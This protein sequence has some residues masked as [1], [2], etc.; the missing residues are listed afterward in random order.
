MSLRLIQLVS[1]F[2]LLSLAV[3]AQQPQLVPQLPPDVQQPGQVV[4]K[5][6]PVQGPEPVMPPD[7]QPQTPAQVP[8]AVQPVVTPAVVNTAVPSTPTQ[9]APKSEPA[10]R[11]DADK[12]AAKK[13]VAPVKADAVP[14]AKSVIATKTKLV[15]KG[16]GKK[17]P[18]K[19]PDPAPPPPPPP[20]LTPEQQ[21]P[22]PP[23]VS[24]L[25]GQ[26]TI[27]STNATLSAILTAIRQQ[28]GAQID[29]P[30]GAGSERVATRIGPGS[31]R[32]VLTSLLAGSAFDYV[33]LGNPDSPGS[34]QRV[35]LTQRSGGAGM[36]NMA[37]QQP[38]ASQPAADENSDEDNTEPDTAIEEQPAPVETPQPNPAVAGQPQPGMQQ[39]QQ[40]PTPG[41]ATPPPDQQGQQGNQIKTPEQLYQELQRLQQQQ[42]Q[43]Q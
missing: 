9:T 7:M 26:L 1:I 41:T 10:L 43:K 42:Q 18:E 40:M 35:I 15:A 12:T 31:P 39:P 2:A 23:Q 17:E 3:A 20:P 37:A 38:V 13:P 11:P 16:K 36:T 32:D 24:Y 14:P 30:S 8:P 21:A 22:I 28:T 4:T 33:I 19:T 6:T 25:N 5:P 29:L 34:I 27:Q